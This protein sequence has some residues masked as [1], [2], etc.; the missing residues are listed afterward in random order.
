MGWLFG[1]KAAPDALRPFVP[2]W[3]RNGEE[4]G[5][6]RSDRRSAR[7]SARTLSSHPRRDGRPNRA[8]NGRPK[9][10]VQRKPAG[11]RRR[12]ERNLVDP[13]AGRSRRIAPR[14]AAHRPTLGEV[15]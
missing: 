10:A 11:H 6:A 13:A 9:R 12:R 3:L 2:A 15:Q 1:R 8:R 4:E 7:G 5:F 14:P